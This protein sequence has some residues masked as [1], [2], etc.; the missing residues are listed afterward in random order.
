MRKSNI[1]F[2]IKYLIDLSTIDA[3]GC[4]CGEFEFMKDEFQLILSDN[5]TNNS[6]LENNWYNII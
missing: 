5:K 2:I 1:L 3:S 4:P 6:A